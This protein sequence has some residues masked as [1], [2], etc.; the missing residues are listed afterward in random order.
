MKLTEH[1]RKAANDAYR[2]AMQVAREIRMALDDTGDSQGHLKQA[3]NEA[4]EVRATLAPVL[5]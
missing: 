3:L 1:Q 5:P 2:A 4:E